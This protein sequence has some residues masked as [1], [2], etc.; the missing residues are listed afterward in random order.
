MAYLNVM[1][2]F[3]QRGDESVKHL[4]TLVEFAQDNFVVDIINVG[5]AGNDWISVV[6]Y[7]T[8][9]TLISKMQMVRRNTYELMDFQ[10]END[11]KAFNNLSNKVRRFV[12]AYSNTYNV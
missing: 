4:P 7:N 2:T 3:K 5:S 6:A 12:G 1:G 11:L 8:P 9:G 10:S